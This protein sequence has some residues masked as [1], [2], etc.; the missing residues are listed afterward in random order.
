MS[1]SRVLAV[2][3]AALVVAG[4]GTYA[5]QG[6]ASG[7]K[8]GAVGGLVAGAVGSLF[9]GGNALE[10]AVASAAVGAASGAAVGAM[11]GNQRD[12]AAAA[13]A[14]VQQRNAAL[15]ELVGEANAAAGEALARCQHTTAM[16]RAD[17]AF[18]RESDPKRQGYALLIKAM[19]AEES[20]NRAK[21]D[22]AYARWAA[23]DQAMADRNAARATVLDDLLKL[24]KLRQDNGLPAVCT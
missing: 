4:C 17:R 16:S 7:A 15:R 6:A 3:G 12:Q 10:N 23:L 24:Q 21:A 18:E 11:S 19:A 2:L 20:G 5:Q 9:W 8:T 14:E 22:E 1:Q 13:A